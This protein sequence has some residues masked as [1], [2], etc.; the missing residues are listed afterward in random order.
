M[1]SLKLHIQLLV[2]VTKTIN[3]STIEH[4]YTK[5]GSFKVTVIVNGKENGEVKKNKVQTV[6]DY[7]N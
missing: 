7:R 5:Y 2:T 4:I 1:A 6:K 3:S